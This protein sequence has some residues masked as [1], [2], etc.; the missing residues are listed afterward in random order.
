MRSYA[1]AFEL[2]PCSRSSGPYE[3]VGA[4]PVTRRPHAGRSLGE[5]SLS[6]THVRGAGKDPSCRPRR[7]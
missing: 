4:G 2:R 1:R 3:F 7:L 5:H 6:I